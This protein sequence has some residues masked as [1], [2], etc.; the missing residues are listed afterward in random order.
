MEVDGKNLVMGQFMRES[1]EMENEKAK[2]YLQ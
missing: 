1:F 2:G